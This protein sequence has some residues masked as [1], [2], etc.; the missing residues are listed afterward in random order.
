MLKS[1]LTED[2][3]SML[4]TLRN[5]SMAENS[6][7]LAVGIESSG[8]PCT[9]I[10]KHMFKEH[11]KWLLCKS[12]VVTLYEAEKWPTIRELERM[13]RSQEYSAEKYKVC[14]MNN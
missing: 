3:S 10:L 7:R 9:H 13:K 1:G 14:E 4:V 2:L 5:M 8:S 12:E 6:Q 11:V